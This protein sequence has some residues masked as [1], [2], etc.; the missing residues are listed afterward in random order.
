MN[1]GRARAG[2]VI[3]LIAI[4]SAIAGAAIDHAVR[5]QIPRRNPGQGGPPG[6]RGLPAAER[7]AK[8]RADLLDRMTKELNLSATQ[9]AGIDSV[10]QRTD[11]SLRVVRGEMEPRLRA[12]FDSSRA[13]IAARLDSTQ[14]AKF[15]KARERGRRP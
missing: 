13:H 10:M 14:R 5:G 6:Y 9:R 12:V 8:R 7:D 11:S 15:L 2:L 3:G 4:C 1:G